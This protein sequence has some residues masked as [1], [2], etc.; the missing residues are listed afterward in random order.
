MK[1]RTPA[2]VSPKIRRMARIWDLGW[3]FGRRR[4]LGSWFSPNN[5]VDFSILS[6][7]SD[8]LRHLRACP[9]GT[10]LSGRSGTASRAEVRPS[11]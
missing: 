1:R 7:I 4:H 2:F 9:N 11:G 10:S 5:P 3:G 8:H 6:L